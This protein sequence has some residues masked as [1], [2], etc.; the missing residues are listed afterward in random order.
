MGKKGI[1]DQR[2]II[3]EVYTGEGNLRIVLSEE[4]ALKSRLEVW[5][6]A[7]HVNRVG[8][9]NPGRGNQN[10][11]GRNLAWWRCWTQDSVDGVPEGL[12][13]SAMILAFKMQ[14]CFNTIDRE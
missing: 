7:N 4:V 1:L 3:V 5:N 6:E 12:V 9:S 11:K 14:I 10:A 2:I 13:G 8:K